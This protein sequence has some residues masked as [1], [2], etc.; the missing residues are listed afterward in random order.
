MSDV[1]F[2]AMRLEVVVALA[3]LADGEYQ[4]RTWLDY[5]RSVGARDNLDVFVHTLYDDCNVLPEPEK[6]L[7]TVL[8]PGDEVARLRAL[9]AVLGPLIDELGDVADRV[10]LE[11]AR[12][13][14]IRET[15]GSAL[16]AMILNGGLGEP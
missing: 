4:Q 13:P 7:W 5:D 10:F 15:A 8:L 3:A 9:D 11:D 1:E 6:S 12:W 14:R 16:T 2:P